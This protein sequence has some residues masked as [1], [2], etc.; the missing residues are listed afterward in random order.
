MSKENKKSAT[1][2]ANK[3][4]SIVEAIGQSRGRFFGMTTRQG[5]TI[6]AQFVSQTPR[7]VIVRDRN[8]SEIRKFAKTSLETVSMGKVRI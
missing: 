4:N 7:Y 6:N 2:Q 3:T 5:E 8:A 1:K